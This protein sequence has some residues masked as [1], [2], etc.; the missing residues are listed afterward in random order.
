MIDKIQISIGIHIK[1]VECSVAQM[2]CPS[3]KLYSVV[4]CAL[5]DG[6]HRQDRILHLIFGQCRFYPQKNTDDG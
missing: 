4:H 5:H 2:L 6:I 3:P 1:N